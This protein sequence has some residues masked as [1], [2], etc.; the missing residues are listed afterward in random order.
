[1]CGQLAIYKSMKLHVYSDLNLRYFQFTD[2][3]DEQL[4]AVD[5]AVVP[6]NISNSCKRSLLFQETIGLTYH[7]PVLTNIGHLELSGHDFYEDVAKAMEIRFASKKEAGCYYKF[8]RNVLIPEQSVDALQLV[9][10]P[11]VASDDEMKKL[12]WH[13]FSL[14]VAYGTFYNND[15]ELIGHV[16]KSP[17]SA[18][19]I[20][21]L[22]SL[23][24]KLL[25]QWLQTPSEFKKILV[26]GNLVDVLDADLDFTGVTV[27][28]VGNRFID[29]PFRGG[30]LICNPGSGQI[31]RSREFE[32]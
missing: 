4:P 12:R 30:R 9:G 18:E 17:M 28:A 21:E 7:V 23:E 20:N 29:E 24:Q 2:P 5:L 26:L 1:M 15:G 10:F 8:R 31:P 27:V 32:I 3:I 13:R 6:G 14:K 11:Q 22:H 19:I 16:D 25:K